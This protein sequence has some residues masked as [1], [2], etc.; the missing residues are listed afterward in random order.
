MPTEIKST[1]GS[2]PSRDY[3]TIQAWKTA[4][5][6]F[7]LVG[8]DRIYLGELYMDD[9]EGFVLN[10]ATQ[11]A[12]ANPNT[13][14][15]QYRRLAPAAGHEF[16]PYSDDGR[17]GV[18][19]RKEFDFSADDFALRIRETGFRIDGGI[20]IFGSQSL[21][22]GAATAHRLILVQAS[23]VYVEGVHLEWLARGVD[24]D[25]V[26]AL[27]LGQSGS[28]IASSC[29]VH[30][31]LV[32]GAGI[33]EGFE[34]GVRLVGT[35][36]AM[37]GHFLQNS[38]I[39]RVSA[40]SAPKGIHSSLTA[41][42]AA[43]KCYNVAVL[44]TGREAQ[45][46]VDWT[47]IAEGA[48]WALGGCA[49]E[50]GT[51]PL[52]STETDAVLIGPADFGS[53]DGRDFR[54]RLGSL[55]RTS[56]VD[57][58]GDADATKT[59][60]DGTP[61]FGA[62]WGLGPHQ[63]AAPSSLGQQPTVTTT[64]IGKGL[65]ISHPDQ[66]E[67][68]T[69]RHLVSEGARELGVLADGVYELDNDC[70]EPEN[71]SLWTD[72]TSQMETGYPAESDRA[73][74]FGFGRMWTFRTKTT[75]TTFAGM[76]IDCGKMAAPDT[77]NVLTCRVS[78]R[79]ASGFRLNIVNQTL[80]QSHTVDY[81]WTA[82]VPVFKTF[83][84]T[85]T[86][87]S[88]VAGPFNVGGI[89][90]YEIAHAYKS[91][92]GIDTTAHDRHAW[93]YVPEGGSADNTDVQ[94]DIGFVRM[95]TRS[96]PLNPDE[97]FGW[98][99]GQQVSPGNAGTLSFGETGFP[100]VDST[101]YRELQGVKRYDI[102]EADGALI[103]DTG[104]AEMIRV[105]EDYLRLV[106]FAVE[107]QH[108]EA[109]GAADQWCV[110]VPA[111]RHAIIDS[112][113]LSIQVG[114]VVND[115]TCLELGRSAYRVSG[116]NVVARGSGGALG[117]SRGFYSDGGAEF[118]DL[119]NCIAHEITAGASAAGFEHDTVPAATVLVRNAIATDCDT[120][121]V[122]VGALYQDSCTASDTTA[123]G[124]GAQ[125]SQ[126]SADLYEDA[127]SGDF[128][129]SPTSA[130]IGSGTSL[131][132]FFSTDF[133][134]LARSAPWERGVFE[135]FA[136]APLTPAAPLLNTAY[137]CTIW[138]IERLDGTTLRFCDVN[139]PITY[140]GQPY[141]P[142]AGFD[143]T[144]RRSQA[145]LAD[146][147]LEATGAV[148][149]AAISDTDLRAGRYRGARVFERLL[150]FRYPFAEAVLTREWVLD[151]LEFDEEIWKAQIVGPADLLT[152]KVG[153][154]ATR[155]CDYDFGDPDTCRANAAAN[156]IDVA[157]TT[158]DD[159]RRTFRASSI[160]GG[161][162]DDYFGAGK[163]LWLTGSN[164]GLRGVVKDYTQTGRIVK[165]Q[166]RQAF[167]IQV[168]DTVRLVPGCRKRFT[169]DCVI[170]HSNGINFGGNPHMPGSDAAFA[171]PQP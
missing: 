119:S 16:D 10:S 57:L 125:D 45:D 29:R 129:L 56:G 121:Y 95:V 38:T 94:G 1:I 70:T 165:L 130:A 120:D 152:R 134:G 62:T 36:S 146:A 61:W 21:D 139:E 144:A 5:D 47:G 132:A 79:D 96:D 98:C 115:N 102:P 151:E 87:I 84:G 117:A 131:S 76:H 93:I 69:R 40:G 49:S 64:Y 141:T 135:G 90:E 12:F 160:S 162:A 51:A 166:V 157:V 149:S 145:G 71:L 24:C 58:S 104:A 53:I 127:S 124:P 6:A 42:A 114:S 22:T 66:W 150:D 46:G 60:W 43:G 74:Y 116:R 34:Y 92:S 110:R 161:Y 20:G 78:E 3:P 108:D 137:L 73:P 128:R 72:G 83:G 103:R 52:A 171:T 106:G 118:C 67:R 153:G 109:T 123:A 113:Y 55:M 169:L 32:R 11:L 147:S 14:A 138:E 35:T 19:I 136:F 23:N 88:T 105:Y 112:L 156:T 163:M 18:R 4:T 111:A 101:R 8:T 25:I 68:K 140:R 31:L 15:T 26:T 142:V 133:A 77:W 48:F 81:E 85:G 168:G 17:T 148:S 164:A 50:D 159:A 91:Q 167:D 158:V 97:S 44:Q 154:I 63:A 107:S 39:A 82:G 170:K 9:D 37:G 13:S 7:D 59:D 41:G 143:A 54:P 28:D 155:R 126:S 33:D 80:S 86:M 2:D 122:Q 30:N 100:V 75:A 99:L 27:E 65:A 89:D